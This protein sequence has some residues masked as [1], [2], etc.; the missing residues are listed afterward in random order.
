M[1]ELA[2]DE[3]DICLEASFETRDQF[4]RLESMRLLRRDPERVTV[5]RAIFLGANVRSLRRGDD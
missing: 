1:V 2:G 4:R 3:A 5:D